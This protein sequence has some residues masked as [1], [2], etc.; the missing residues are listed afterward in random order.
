VRGGEPLTVSDA[1]GDG[2]AAATIVCRDDQLLA[3]LAGELPDGAAIHGD[4]SHLLALLGWLER[5]QRE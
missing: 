5:A 2:P 3:V 4:S 1:P